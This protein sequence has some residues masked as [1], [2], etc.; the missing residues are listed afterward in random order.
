MFS[1]Y[2]YLSFGSQLLFVALFFA[3]SRFG[4]FNSEFPFDTLSLVFF[5]SFCT[6]LTIQTKVFAILW[7]ENRIPILSLCG[8]SIALLKILFIWIWHE[9]IYQVMMAILLAHALIVILTLFLNKYLNIT[10]L[11]SFKLKRIIQF[12]RDEGRFFGVVIFSALIIQSD[13]IIAKTVFSEEIAG[14][15]VTALVL[16]KAVF[17]ITSSLGMVAYPILSRISLSQRGFLILI[18]GTIA[19]GTICAVM[20]YAF[21]EFVLTT[22]YG[23]ISSLTVEVLKIYGFAL[24]PIGIFSIIEHIGFAKGETHILVFQGLLVLFQLAASIWFVSQPSDFSV[25]FLVVNFSVAFMLVGYV[26]YRRFT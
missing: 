23:N 9:D 14:Q 25:A 11:K 20:F 21:S 22:L 24:I 1:N 6:L 15:V 10:K 2:L 18:L 13:V 3:V 26:W 4:I 5:F 16:S 12:L 8:L 17:F 7:G 19:I